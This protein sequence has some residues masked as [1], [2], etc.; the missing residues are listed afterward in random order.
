MAAP[1][2]TRKHRGAGADLG[3]RDF[4]SFLERDAAERFRDTVSRLGS[5]YLS[6]VESTI[7][8]P[9]DQEGTVWDRIARNTEQFFVALTGAVEELDASPAGD[10]AGTTKRA[11]GKDESMTTTL[12]KR[13]E[14]VDEVTR[15]AQEKL[16]KGEAQNLFAA[17]ALVWRERPELN[18]RY[19]EL[20]H[21][22]PEPQPVQAPVRK[23]GAIVDTVN[24]AATELRKQRP[25]LSE[26]EARL[27]IWRSRPDLRELYQQ[28]IT[29]R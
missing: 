14:V 28:A 3:K 4:D 1:R 5:A 15:L 11:I 18:E 17:R 10:V 21:E 12:S 16:Q 6:S 13:S 7:H 2:L 29:R 9:G 8:D 23:G 22:L 27:Q 26:H 20:P 25:E 19:R 24:A